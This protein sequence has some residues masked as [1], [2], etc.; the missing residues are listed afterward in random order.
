[1]PGPAALVVHQVRYDLLALSRNRQSRF[2]TLALP[3]AFLLIF[4]T[5]LRNRTAAVPGSRIDISVYYVPGIIALGIISAALSNLVISVTAQR[6]SGILKCR[7]AAP[8]PADLLITGR[9]LTAATVAMVMTAI[10]AAIGWFVYSAH[11]PARH[12]L[13]L[14]LAGAV[15]RPS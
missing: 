4:A 2:F 7:R 1:V 10:L 12:V 11:V 5:V 8:V 6:E 9:A 15:S 14:L 13:A 3:V